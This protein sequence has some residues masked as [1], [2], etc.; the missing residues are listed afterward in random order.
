M[1][2]HKQAAAL[3]DEMHFYERLAGSLA[4]ASARLAEEGRAR[5]AR[6]LL[7]MARQQRVLGMMRGGIAASLL[8]TEL[9]EAAS[10]ERETRRHG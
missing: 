8:G 10:D 7:K 2:A 4:S 6:V 5:E 9:P 1:S 3:I